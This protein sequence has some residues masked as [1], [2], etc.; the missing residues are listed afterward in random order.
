MREIVKKAVENGDTVVINQNQQ[1]SFS[2]DVPIG[3]TVDSF[4]YD[5][6]VQKKPGSFL[7]GRPIVDN[8]PVPK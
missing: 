7:P 3:Q 2:N 1:L 5:R 4:Q 6:D 8:A